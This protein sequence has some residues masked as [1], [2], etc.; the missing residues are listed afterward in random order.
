M[1]ILYIVTAVI[2]FWELVWAQYLM[3]RVVLVRNCFRFAFAALIP[4]GNVVFAA[5]ALVIL[6]WYAFDTNYFRIKRFMDKPVFGKKYG[7]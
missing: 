4:F 1:K 7:D 2:C 3:Q 6:I 5:V